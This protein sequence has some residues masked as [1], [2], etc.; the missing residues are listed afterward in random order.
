MVVQVVPRIADAWRS[1][2]SG[3]D[4]DYCWRLAVVVATIRT[5][6]TTYNAERR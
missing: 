1:P 4:Y 2:S 3:G 6:R 5:E